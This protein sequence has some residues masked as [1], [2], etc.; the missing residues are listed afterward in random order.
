[1]KYAKRAGSWLVVLLLMFLIGTLTGVVLAKHN[2]KWCVDALEGHS[3]ATK[4]RHCLVLTQN[5]MHQE[6]GA[7]LWLDAAERIERRSAAIRRQ[8]D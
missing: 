4:W 6:K 8:F 1:M 5:Y 3:A 7:D 2:F